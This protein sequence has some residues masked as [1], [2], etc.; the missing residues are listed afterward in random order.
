M[1][2]L[3]DQIRTRYLLFDLNAKEHVEF[4]SSKVLE[5]IPHQSELE[6][7]NGE[8]GQEI[9]PGE[10]DIVLHFLDNVCPP[11]LYQKLELREFLQKKSTQRQEQIRQEDENTGHL[12]MA[13][14]CIR[15]FSY[16]YDAI[17]QPLQEYA[18]PYLTWHLSNVDLAMVDRDLKSQLGESLA[19]LFTTNESIDSLLLPESVS[20]NWMATSTLNAHRL[21]ARSWLKTQETIDEVVRWLRDTAVVSRVTDQAGRSWIENVVS[22][23]ATEAIFKPCAIRL[24]DR[25][26]REAMSEEDI[27]DIYQYVKLFLRVVSVQIPLVV[28]LA[29]C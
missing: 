15:S 26:L 9:H 3:A 19:R 11:R 22:H 24:V 29:S 16:G 28:V 12:K 8:T 10:I 14:D 23:N 18:R 17:I 5:V 27:R 4:R 7:A 25:C 2:P 20:Y 21:E 1:R 6:K 13:L